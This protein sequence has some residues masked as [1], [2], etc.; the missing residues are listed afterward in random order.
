MRDIEFSLLNDDDTQKL[1]AKLASFVK[2]GDFIALF[3]DLGAGKT[4]FARGFIQGALSE[5]IDVPSPTFT[6]LQTYDAPEFQIYHFDLYRLKDP[7]EI[8]E[9]GWE[10]IEN[11][12]TLAEWPQM[13]GDFLPS[14]RLE[15]YIE[16]TPKG[17]KAIL[18]DIG[19]NWAQ[20]LDSVAHEF[21]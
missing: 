14:P 15:I 21:I 18:R 11:G 5:A 7:D 8:W 1:G 20:R 17:R 6:L 16:I 3:G 2:M 12:V 13:A 19:G 10:D 9:L 4:T